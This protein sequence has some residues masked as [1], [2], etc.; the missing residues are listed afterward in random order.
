MARQ[1]SYIPDITGIE[2]VNIPDDDPIQN[3]YG[4]AVIFR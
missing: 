2:K 1:Q 4:S 3:K